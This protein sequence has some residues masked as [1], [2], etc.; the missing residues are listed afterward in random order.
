MI[1]E[2][3]ARKTARRSSP[4]LSGLDRSTL[5][6]IGSGASAHSRLSLDSNPTDAWVG[7]HAIPA[8]QQAPPDMP[9]PPAPR[10]ETSSSASM[11]A[12]LD[13]PTEASQLPRMQSP[14]HEAMDV[15]TLACSPLQ[16]HPRY[17]EEQ[18]ISRSAT[19]WVL[20]A[21]DRQARQQ[22]VIKLLPRSTVDRNRL[23]KDIDNQRA[24][25]RH[26]H[27]VQLH[28]IF[29]LPEYLAIVTSYCNGGNLAKFMQDWA[30]TGGI[31]EAQARFCF[32]QLI[33]ALDFCHTMD[34][35]TRDIKM[36]NVLLH[37]VIG[38]Q[39]PILKLYNFGIVHDRSPEIMA[40]EVLFGAEDCRQ[41]ADIWA[42]GVLLY[43]LL[44]G[45][46]PFVRL[47]DTNETADKRLQAMFLRIIAG[48]FL[49][50][51][52]GSTEVRALLGAMLQP[53]P[54]SRI[55]MESIANHPWFLTDL[56]PQLQNINSDLVSG[57]PCLSG[58]SSFMDPCCQSREELHDV[59]VRAPK[60]ALDRNS[61]PGAYQ[62][63]ANGMMGRSLAP[64]PRL[65]SLLQEQH[66]AEL[67][68]QQERALHRLFDDEHLESQKLM[69][70]LQLEQILLLPAESYPA[71]RE[72]EPVR[73]MSDYSQMIR[74]KVSVQP[75]THRQIGKTSQNQVHT[76]Q[77][78]G[79]WVT[80]GGSMKSRQ[81]S[82]SDLQFPS[83]SMPWLAPGA[84]LLG[85]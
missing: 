3:A 40:P 21:Y 28:E 23:A 4:Q 68:L 39:R 69:P 44:T 34:I 5:L 47:W 30:Q 60:A 76:L 59:T 48:E 17:V 82:V 16:G 55:T 32:Q 62:T 75:H 66:N 18:E 13:V 26:P 71:F 20:L 36:D 35:S 10:S 52:E 42:A 53:A 83:R 22:V 51:S 64:T 61:R 19:S 78:T 31:G 67:A 54:A 9:T 6:R 29:L 37:W 14:C 50:I 2:G 12:A 11:Q 1:Q 15:D 58:D 79:N 24:C 72:P 7:D 43:G 73:C 27:I 45:V 85:Y 49:P 63:D 70:D 38:A 74:P 46:C 57:S 80:A 25:A 41:T 56:P 65:L 8:W 84:E 77:R 33:T 81:N